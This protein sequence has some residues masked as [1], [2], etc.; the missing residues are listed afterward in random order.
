MK[1]DRLQPHPESDVSSF[2]LEYVQSGR[3]VGRR[4]LPEVHTR[5]I[6]Q[7]ETGE[8]LNFAII[9]VAHKNPN[10]SICGGR[11]LPDLAELGFLLHLVDIMDGVEA[12]YP[13]GA[14]FTILTEGEFYRANASIFDVSEEEI[15]RYEKVT[16]DIASAVGRGRITLVSLQSIVEESRE[17]HEKFLSVRQGL[18]GSDYL[19][20]APV[21][22]RSMTERQRLLNVIPEIMAR[23]YAALHKAKHIN[24]ENGDSL[25][26]QYLENALGE[27]Y[28]YCSVTGSMRDEVLNI[29]PMRKS[30][31]LPQHGIGVLGGGTSSIKVIPFTELRGIVEKTQV[32]SII[33]ENVDFSSPFGFINF[34][35]RR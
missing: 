24:G 4:Y 15:L 21:M 25:V 32:G 31:T 18:K 12:I 22:Q 20:Y 1:R 9:A 8:C 35:K 28:I 17:F 30:A 10:H 23:D 29:D 26:Y 6:R 19:M 7:M 11:T 13:P 34:G 16:Q 27:N 33:L 2:L 3:G 14:S 5:I